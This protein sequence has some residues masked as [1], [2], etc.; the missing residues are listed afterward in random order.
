MADPANPT[1]LPPQTN[2]TIGDLLSAKGVSWAW[3]SG[4]WQEALS[5]R[6][7]EPAPNFQYH[8]QPFNYFASMAPGTAERAKHLK[9]GGLAGAGFLAAIKAGSLEQVVFYKPQGN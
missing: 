7:G 6:N 9:D 1:T 8:H 3:Y 2:Q 4:A 5:G